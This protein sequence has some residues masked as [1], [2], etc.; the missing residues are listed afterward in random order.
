MTARTLAGAAI[1][2]GLVLLA[3]RAHADA[4]AKPRAAVAVSAAEGVDPFVPVYVFE[5]GAA[6]L[7]EGGFDVAPPLATRAI[8]AELHE[9]AIACAADDECTTLLAERA[10]APMVL[11]VAVTSTG[12]A[13]V[14]VQV[15]GAR[16]R[17]D[18]ITRTDAVDARGGEAA[19]GEPVAT[20]ARA[21][22]ALEAPC[23]LELAAEPGAAIDVEVDGRPGGRAGATLFLPAGE[24]SLRITA[25]GR[26][27]FS[28]SHVCV[29]GRRYRVR[30]R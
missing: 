3:G 9:D 13:R 11:F 19:M 5:V 26:A 25:P 10:G 17:A 18:G 24:H 12:A 15:R 29:A 6:V 16:V 28:G 30:V 22:A 7:R 8:L 14:S 4:P 2:V 21:L 20:A 1:A 23:E 27:P